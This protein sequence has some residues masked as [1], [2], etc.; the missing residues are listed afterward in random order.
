MRHIIRGLT[1]LIIPI[2]VEGIL[3]LLRQP[4]KAEPGKVYLHKFLAIF[5]TI[6]SAMFLIPAMITAFSDE[7][8]WVP[9]SFLAFSALGA[10][11]LIGFINCRIW[12]D[13]E[14]FVAKN[15]LGIKR[16]F[17]YEQVTAIREDLR[18]SYLYMGERWV[19]IDQLSVGGQEFLEVVKKRYRI[20]HGGMS[21]P[22]MKKA[23]HDIFNG[24]VSDPSGF[25]FAYILLAV[26]V[27]AFLIFSVY[28]VFFDLSTENN[29]IEQSVS[30]VSCEI[31]DKNI[32]LTS[33]ENQTYIIRFTNERLDAKN[34]RAICD[35][36]TV[37]TTYST[38]VKPEEAEPYYS[39]KAIRYNGGYL[40]SFDETNQF[41]RQEF[42]P[43][44]LLALGMC[45][46]WG[47]YV[48]LSIVVGRNPRKFSRKFVRL[49]FKDGYIKY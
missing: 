6:C 3:C 49:F 19:M 33:E 30:F 16:R 9:I 12:Y 36:K 14:G 23:K 24:N 4:Q 2:L 35:G 21:L 47:G 18:E 37:V 44:I 7:P 34:I 25:L 32:V 5:G 1:F 48:A 13:E 15:F 46:L 45:V 38:E 10:S 29:T 26:V 27:V 8:I 39:V 40:L 41:H 31:N 17:T 22:K 20:M 43:I 42:W 11:L 28:C